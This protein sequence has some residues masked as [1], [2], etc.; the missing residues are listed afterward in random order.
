MTD[1]EILGLF[2]KTEFP[3]FLGEE[4]VEDFIENKTH[5]PETFKFT[6]NTGASKLVILPFDADFVIK[7]P[8]NGQYFERREMDYETGEII[9]ESGWEPFTSEE[10]Y[11]E[12]MDFDGNYC[13]R[14]ADISNIAAA[15][16]LDECFAITECIGRCKGYLIYK[17]A[18]A[19][20]ILADILDEKSDSLSVE[21]R[22]SI[23]DKCDSMGVY[24][25]NVYWLNDF[26]EFF[27]E[28]ILKQ[29]NR[30]IDTYDI[31]DLHSS[32]VGYIGNRPVLIDYS[33]Y[34]E[35]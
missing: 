27:G 14:E 11:S 4:N 6:W 9:S 26:L 13:G 30:F 7:I 5:F 18:R 34:F 33:G 2:E 32:N 25:F 3:E 22:N 24:R 19:T 12:D 15:E 8:F 29:L 10:Y 1:A 21:E 28:E 20:A 31:N 35:Q 23:R 16:D 17:Q